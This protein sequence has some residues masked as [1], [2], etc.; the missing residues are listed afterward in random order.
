VTPQVV[1]LSAP[2]G[3]GK[4]TISRTLLERYPDRFAYS[5]S[6]TTRRPRPGEEDGKAY[7]F[8]TRPEFQRR[9]EAGEFVE[10]AQYAGE[11]YGT[12]KSGIEQD[13]K[14]VVLDIEVQGARQVRAA[15]PKP[16]SITIFLVPPSAAVLIGRLRAR[17]TETAAEIGRRID[18]AVE[19][20]TAAQEDREAKIF[21]RLVENADL[22][23]AIAEVVETVREARRA[24]PRTSHMEALLL[25]LIRGLRSERAARTP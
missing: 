2:S 8:L 23:T 16:A 17:R 24:W 9:R 1:V 22:E 3:G 6:A 25:E 10:W 21:D 12:L 11:W 13:G 4:T 20:I 5:V 19:E 7:R 18:I 14:H 15:Y